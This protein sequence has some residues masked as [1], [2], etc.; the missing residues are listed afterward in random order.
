MI[1]NPILWGALIIVGFV[2]GYFIRQ[3]IVSKKGDSA[4]RKIRKQLEEAESKALVIT[5]EAQ[6]KAVDLLEELKKEEREQKTQLSR[7]EDRLV[8]KEG[9]LEKQQ[10]DL[11]LQEDQIKEDVEKIKIA[12]IQ[13]AELRERLSSDLEKNIQIIAGGSERKTSWRN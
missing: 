6:K 7:I 11:R 12:K 2:A 3:I 13:I 4:D 5:L 1:Q 9:L 8:N 10:S